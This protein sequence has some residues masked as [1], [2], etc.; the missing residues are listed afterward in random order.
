MSKV[1][2][3]VGA[4]GQQGGSVINWVSKHPTLSEEFKIRALTRNPAKASF[5]SGVE[6][7]QAD[8]NDVE[9]LKKA[10]QDSDTVFGVTNYW[11]RCDK[12]FEKQQGINI[13]DAAIAVG[14]RHLIWSSSTNVAKHTQGRIKDC[15]YFDNKAEVMEY[16]E[17]K[18]G[19]IIVSYPTPAVFM[20]TLI[21]LE[22]RRFSDGGIVWAK[23]WDL[24]H[25]RVP[26]V[27]VW[28][29]GA[30][31]AGIMAADHENPGS[32]NGVKVLGTA[33]WLNPDKVVKD[34]SEVLGEDVRF[35]EVS[36]EQFRNALPK[37]HPA[38]AALTA[39]MQWMRD[40]GYFGPG[41]EERHMESLK[42]VEAM[43]LKTWREWLQQQMPIKL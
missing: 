3:V 22:I 21:N 27:D 29:S 43:H 35:V 7:I 9:S 17:S 8:F 6:V 28:D 33:E 40:P 15:E 41:A 24:N 5:P 26:L 39:N 20:Q 13:A 12:D 38:P 37:E 34:L 4:T 18:K 23:P 19:D 2:T 42:F 16:L 10:F 31:V 32:V 1:L 36:N 25:T 14:V 30:F 11:E